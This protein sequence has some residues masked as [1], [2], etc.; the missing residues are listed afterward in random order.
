MKLYQV[1]KS[2]GVFAHDTSAQHFGE[3]ELPLAIT[4]L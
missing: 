1:D 3:L 2:H 4:M